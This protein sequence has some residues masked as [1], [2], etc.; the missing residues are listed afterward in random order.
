MRELGVCELN[1]M[2][3]LGLVSLD[4]AVAGEEISS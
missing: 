3:W 2:G 1:G 4:A